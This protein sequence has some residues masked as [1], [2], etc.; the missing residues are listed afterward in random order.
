MIPGN[1]T[2]SDDVQLAAGGQAQDQ[3]RRDRIALRCRAGILQP[4]LPGR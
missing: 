4:D 1:W 2:A 3:S